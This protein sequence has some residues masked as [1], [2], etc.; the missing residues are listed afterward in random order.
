MKWVDWCRVCNAYSPQSQI[1]ALLW[2]G[3][4]IIAMCRPRHVQCTAR[5][6]Q[7]TCLF[8]CVHA[9]TR[10]ALPFELWGKNT[11]V[12]AAKFQAVTRFQGHHS[13]RYCDGACLGLK[14]MCREGHKTA[15]L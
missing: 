4:A 7:A 15:R 9:R 12:E 3:H 2:S 1:S 10:T 14:E 5:A 11:A 6:L 13:V 8:R